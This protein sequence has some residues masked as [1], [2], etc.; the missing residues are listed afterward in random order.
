MANG[1]LEASV[2]DEAPGE[3]R[4][5]IKPS[6][7]VK[8]AITVVVSAYVL[9]RANLGEAVNT[10]RTADWWFVALAI[11][12][13]AIAMVINVARW[14]LMLRGQAS[15]SPLPTLVRFY[16]IGMFFSN[17]LPSR[18]G[19]DVVRAYGVATT[20]TSKIGSAAAVLMDRLVGAIS[21]L[22]LG[23]GATLLGTSDLPRELQWTTVYACLAA[24]VVLATMVYRND[25]LAAFRLRVLEM[26]DVSV[27]GFRPRAR[28]EQALNALRTYSRRPGLIGRGFLISLV[29]NGFS[30]FNLYL[31]ARAVRV[32]VGL[33]DVATIAPFVLAVGL[34]P[35]SINGIGT[36]ELAFVIL[37]GLVGVPEPA[38]LAIA[39]LRRLSL[40]VLSLAGGA[41]Y[42]ARRFS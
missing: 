32:D 11:S 27:F 35:I 14:Q 9:S 41:L 21:V 37:F 8:L 28:L 4:P 19:L 39:L 42:A 2:Q 1:V 6:T 16:L 20:G 13:S 31:Y 26:L 34:L 40:L 38:A 36:I 33:G 12:I 15:D 25:N 10:L 5:R 7:V 18:L 24:V 22:V 23:V 29:A 17:I 3:P 30:M